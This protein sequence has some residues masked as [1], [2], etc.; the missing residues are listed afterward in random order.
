MD[1]SICKKKIDNIKYPEAPE[2][3]KLRLNCN[4][5]G[6]KVGEKARERNDVNVV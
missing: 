5:L 4:N 3:I 1:G 6:N 2:T